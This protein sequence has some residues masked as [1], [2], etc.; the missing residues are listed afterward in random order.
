[1]KFYKLLLLFM[2][3]IC[4]TMMYS[5]IGI[6]TQTPDTSAALHIVA[7]PYGQGLLIPRLTQAQRITI[8]SPAKGLMVYDI[9]DDMFYM[10]LNAGA[11][12]W[13]AINPWITNATSGSTSSMYT[14]TVVTKVGIGTSS[15]SVELDVNGSITSN[16]VVTTNTLNVSGFPSNAL[17]PAGI[18][19]MWSGSIGSIPFGWGLCNGTNGT[20]DLS[21]RFILSA[22]TNSAPAVG[23]LNPNYL[24]GQIGGENTHTLTVNE[25]PTHNHTG[26][27]GNDSPDHTHD[28]WAA[29]NTGFIGQNGSSATHSD[30][31]TITS[32]GASNRHQHSIPSQGGGQPH[33]NRPPYYVLAFIMKLP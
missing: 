23:D 5:Q 9:T 33:E 13:F 7:K 27:T 14:H 29:Y 15:P 11:S 21:G 2:F 12:S 16:S 18:I 32:G 24:V 31:Q 22:G 26:T 4:N 20:P 30:N 6:N 1:M 17:V 19:V 10:N 28:S 3:L 8:T 25:M